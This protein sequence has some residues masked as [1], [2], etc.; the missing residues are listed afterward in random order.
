MQPS[1]VKTTNL[2]YTFVPTGDYYF[3]YSVSAKYFVAQL[4]T[5]QQT[6]NY[7]PSAQDRQT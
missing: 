7:N 6:Y 5:I 3:P 2:F 4:V 1:A